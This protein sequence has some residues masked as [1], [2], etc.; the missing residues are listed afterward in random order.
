MVCSQRIDLKT[1]FDTFRA[2]LKEWLVW[3]YTSS[4]DSDLGSAVHTHNLMFVDD[5]CDSHAI[6]P[7]EIL[8]D[9]VEGLL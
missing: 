4:G 3:T 1:L 9:R 7:S 2:S 6:N 8:H 5:N